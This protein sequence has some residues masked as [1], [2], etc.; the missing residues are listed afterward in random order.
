MAGAWTVAGSLVAEGL[1]ADEELLVVL[2]LEVV[3]DDVA[4][5]GWGVVSSP[6]PQAERS[7]GTANKIGRNFF[8]GNPKNE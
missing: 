5:V 4:E 6:L 1:E 7:N 2:E 3:L 8:M